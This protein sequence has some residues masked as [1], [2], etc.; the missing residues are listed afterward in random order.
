MLEVEYR[1]RLQETYPDR[2][3]LHDVEIA[4]AKVRGEITE[5]DAAVEPLHGAP[6]QESAPE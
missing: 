5:A 2:W 1:K 3:N 4:A 6:E